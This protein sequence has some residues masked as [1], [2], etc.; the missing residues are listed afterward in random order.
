[1]PFEGQHLLPS[2]DPD[3]M[4]LSYQ[5]QSLGPWAFLVETSLFAQFA[6]PM[7]RLN[8]AILPFFRRFRF[9]T[10]NVKAALFSHLS[11]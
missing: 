9:W 6:N 3:T 11:A 8:S 5:N 1:M 2:M 7:M 10:E 4:L